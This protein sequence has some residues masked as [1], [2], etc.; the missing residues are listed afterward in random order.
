MSVAVDLNRLTQ[1]SRL[2]S[3]SSTI[4]KGVSF[5]NLALL[6]TMSSFMSKRD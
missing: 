6:A 2:G 1:K 4:I 5:F 3:I